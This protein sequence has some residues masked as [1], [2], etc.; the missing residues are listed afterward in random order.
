MATKAKSKK[1]SSNGKAKH[2][3]PYQKVA[4][5]WSEGKTLTE[6]AKAVGKYAEGDPNPLNPIS[7]FV[8]KM[9]TRGW[10]DAEGK[11]HHLPYR[12][13][14]AKAAHAKVVAKQKKAEA[15]HAEKATE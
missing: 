10:K 5:M 6:I 15:R 11:L 14:D 13:Q 2:P 3:F 12:N 8:Y 9:H 4:D 1:A 7:P